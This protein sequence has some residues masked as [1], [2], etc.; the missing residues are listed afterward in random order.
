MTLSDKILMWIEKEIKKIEDS[1]AKKDPEDLSWNNNQEGRYETLLDI[2]RR[3]YEEETE[4]HPD[5]V[6]TA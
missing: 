3:F 4:E 6:E 1:L 2:K 5:D